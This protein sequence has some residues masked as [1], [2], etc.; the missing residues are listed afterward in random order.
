MFQETN[1]STVNSPSTASNQ[2]NDQRF[3]QKKD[4]TEEDNGGEHVESPA[5]DL[6]K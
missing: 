3:K 6:N 5:K 2:R 1:P 4:N